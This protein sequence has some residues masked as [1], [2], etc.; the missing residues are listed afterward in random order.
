MNKHLISARDCITASYFDET[1]LSIQESTFIAVKINLDSIFNV[2]SIESR[3]NMKGYPRLCKSLAK[4]GM[5]E[6]IIVIENTAKNL[7][8][9]FRGVKYNYINQESPDGY[10]WL[11]LTG[12]SRLSFAQDYFYDSISCYIVPSLI[13]MHAVQLIQQDGVIKHEV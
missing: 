5:R 4:D 3:R 2:V 12:N 7:I 11:A 13:Y 9:C 6:P 1:D 10:R 8:S